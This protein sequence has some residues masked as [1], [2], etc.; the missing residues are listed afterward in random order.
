MIGP[1][2]KAWGLF[3]STMWKYLTPATLLFILFFNWIDYE[4]LKSGN[5]VFPGWANAIGWIIAFQSVAVIVGVLVWKF[6]R[7]SEGTVKERFLSL[8]SPRD[9]WGPAIDPKLK[10]DDLGENGLTGEIKP[11]HNSHVNVT[12][13]FESSI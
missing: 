11:F 3:W 8:L 2:S 7:Q 1:R 9:D 4:P 6:V 13:T 12:Y 5:Y 10:S